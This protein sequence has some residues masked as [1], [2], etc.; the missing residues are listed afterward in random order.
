MTNWTLFEMITL[1]LNGYNKVYLVD[2]LATVYFLEL[3]L[4]GKQTSEKKWKCK[5][6]RCVRIV[7]QSGA[8]ARSISLH[9]WI[10]TSKLFQ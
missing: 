1:H 3:A 4:S 6:R 5:S 9:N 8:P 10:S 2:C 7:G